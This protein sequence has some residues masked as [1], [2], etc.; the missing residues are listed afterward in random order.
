MKY[1]IIALS[2]L[3]FTGCS[4]SGVIPIGDGVYTLSKLSPACGFSDGEGAKTDL[5]KEA[6]VFCSEKNQEI[7]VVKATARKGVVFVRC[8]GADLEFRCVDKKN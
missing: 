7:S 2:M 1:L 6:N 4:S 8:A 3:L 5:Y